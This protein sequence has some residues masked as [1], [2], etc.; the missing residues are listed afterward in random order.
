MVRKA[1]QGLLAFMLVVVD[2]DQSNVTAHAG[3]PLTIEALR[4]AISNKVYRRLRKPLRYKEWRVVRR[5]LES[6]VVLM[7]AGGD[8]VSDIDALRAAFRRNQVRFP[9]RHGAWP[10]CWALCR[11]RPRSSRSS[12]TASTRPTTA[13]P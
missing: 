6:L 4:A 5:H 11:R 1:F 7:V 3:V 12:C 9:D 10:G 2:D 13:A 8:H